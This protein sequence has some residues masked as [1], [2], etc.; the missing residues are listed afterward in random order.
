[1][2]LGGSCTWVLK[3]HTQL[4]AYHYTPPIDE[5]LL[6]PH[7][8]IF[9]EYGNEAFHCSNGGCRENVLV[10]WDDTYDGPQKAALYNIVCLT[11]TFG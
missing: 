7:L 2:S 4:F 1:M 3:P 11:R 10:S 9:L 8:Y 5:E 6:E